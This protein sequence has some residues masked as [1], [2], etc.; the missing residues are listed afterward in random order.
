M[1]HKASFKTKQKIM[2]SQPIQIWWGIFQWTLF[3]YYSSVE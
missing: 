1:E 2:P 3:R